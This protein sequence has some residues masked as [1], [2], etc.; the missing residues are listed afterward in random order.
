MGAG[1]RARWDLTPP[2]VPSLLRV[3]GHRRGRIAPTSADP[4]GESLRPQNHPGHPPGG[5]HKEPGSSG[6]LFPAGEGRVRG[7]GRGYLPHGG[8]P[9]RSIPTRTNSRASPCP[10]RL[11][12]LLNYLAN[13]KCF[14]SPS[15]P[16]SGSCSYSRTLGELWGSR[17]LCHSSEPPPGTTIVCVRVPPPRPEHL[18][19]FL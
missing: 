14:G 16:L 11:S 3:R 1:Q 6:E 10:P 9:R 19:T 13:G 8:G 15:K 17:P 12:P 5:V 2:Q 7:D 18:E 4:V